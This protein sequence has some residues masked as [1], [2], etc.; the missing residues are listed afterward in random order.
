MSLAIW[1]R[2]GTVDF[3]EMLG[4]IERCDFAAMFS[5]Q[6][7]A[8]EAAV[9]VWKG[10]RHAVAGTWRP[11]LSTIAT[12]QRAWQLGNGSSSARAQSSMGSTFASDTDNLRSAEHNHSLSTTSFE[13]S[14][15]SHDLSYL[16][17]SRVTPAGEAIVRSA[18]ARL[19]NACH[20]PIWDLWKKRQTIVDVALT[21][22]GLEALHEALQHV[23]GYSG[24]DPEAEAA[25]WGLA[26]DLV[27]ITP[28]SDNPGPVE[29]CGDFV[30]WLR[31]RTA[32]KLQSENASFSRTAPKPPRRRPRVLPAV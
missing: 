6:E 13:A 31:D 14:R 32:L 19:L 8:V 10:G 15:A 11:Q 18:Y 27:T 2:F 30:I 29:W 9:Q 12:E 17:A 5:L 3:A 1:R 16:R 24:P 22:G 25:G 28:L 21:T 23:K 7:R 26:F 20:H 4:W